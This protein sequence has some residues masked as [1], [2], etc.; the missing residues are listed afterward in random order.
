M[1]RTLK[2]CVSVVLG[3]VAGEGQVKSKQMY[4][5]GGDSTFAFRAYVFELWLTSRSTSSTTSTIPHQL[6]QTETIQ[7]TTS[8]YAN[9]NE[10]RLTPSVPSPGQP[11]HY[12][13]KAMLGPDGKSVT[14]ADGKIVAVDAEGRPITD[15]SSTKDANGKGAVVNGKK[16]F[17]KKMKRVFLVPEEVRP[18]LRKE[19]FQCQCYKSGHTRYSH[20]SRWQPYSST[21]TATPLCQRLSHP[22]PL[23][24]TPS[25][26]VTTSPSLSSSHEELQAKLDEEYGQLV[27]DRR[28]LRKFISPRASTSVPHYLPVDLHHIMQNALQI[29]HLD[30]R[31]P[32]NLDPAYT[33]DSAMGKRLIVV[34]GDESTQSRG[35]R[36]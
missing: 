2:I 6:H 36:E 9:P 8:E 10:S 18:Q 33:V 32:S 26:E 34:H 28:T 5:Y 29:F 3:A 35:A 13:G 11:G 12:S 27:E 22:P 14:S 24:F 31:K 7:A 25:F 23:P 30:R 15:S 19:E 21:S 20:M 17:Q 1:S 4:Q 16:R